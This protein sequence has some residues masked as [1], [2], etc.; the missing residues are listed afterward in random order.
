MAARLHVRRLCS[1]A[2]PMKGMNKFSSRITQPKSQGASQAMLHALGLNDAQLALPQRDK[3]EMKAVVTRGREVGHNNC[4]AFKVLS[5]AFFRGCSSRL[6]N[7]QLSCL[8]TIRSCDPDCCH[9]I[10]TAT[11]KLNRRRSCV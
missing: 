3:R 10:S 1:S 9:L 7:C 5:T 8:H 2:P 6:A 11:Y 4:V